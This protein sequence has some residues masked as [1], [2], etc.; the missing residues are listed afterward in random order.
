MMSISCFLLCPIWQILLTNSYGQDQDKII[1]QINPLTVI[2]LVSI[3]NIINDY[4]DFYVIFVS[5]SMCNVYSA[6]L[7]RRSK[8]RK[9]VNDEFKMRNSTIS[10]QYT[11]TRLYVFVL[12]NVINLED[13]FRVASK[14]LMVSCRDASMRKSTI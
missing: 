11:N 3:E 12:P 14:I 2:K 10:K 4:I 13:K 1:Y 6:C 5:E 8:Q 7:S 9:N